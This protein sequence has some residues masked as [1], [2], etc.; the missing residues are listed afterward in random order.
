MPAKGELYN[1][2]DVD[3]AK[4]A[5]DYMRQDR[6]NPAQPARRLGFG[7]QRIRAYE[8]VKGKLRTKKYLDIVV[9]QIYQ[10]DYSVMTRY[11]TKATKQDWE[12]EHWNFFKGLPDKEKK[13]HQA[14]VK[15]IQR[16]Q[17]EG[18]LSEWLKKQKK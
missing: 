10:G 18:T 3:L 6:I 2:V 15:E 8:M 13:E 1:R 16:M 5:K 11:A 9:N 12:L 4:W 7:D 17:R 14:A